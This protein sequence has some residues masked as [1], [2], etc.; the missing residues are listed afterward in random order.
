MGWGLLFKIF[1]P[2]ASA[3]RG[4]LPFAGIGHALKVASYVVALG[5]GA[6]CGVQAMNWLH[7]D[8]ITIAQSNERCVS[9]I[10][11]ATLNAKLAAVDAREHALRSR[12]ERVASDEEAVKA[13]I[14]RM[15]DDRAKSTKPG[16]S[17]VLSRADDE[18]L[19]RWRGSKPAS[20]SGRL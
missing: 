15:G 7:G 2:V 4:L 19:Q 6:W 1:G 8:K 20:G 16:D 11:M 12:E 17:G 18:W 3:A 9:A 5:A 10:S 14:E 13:A